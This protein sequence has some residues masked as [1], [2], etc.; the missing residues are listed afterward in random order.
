[1]PSATRPFIPLW[2]PDVFDRRGHGGEHDLHLPAKEVGESGP[3][4]AIWLEQNDSA[5]E[6]F[7]LDQRVAKTARRVCPVCVPAMMLTPPSPNGMVQ[8]RRARSR[9]WGACSRSPIP[10]L[11]A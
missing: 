5:G 8:T 7:E 1:M 2:S 4:A 9:G 10:C 6:K 11:P 3:T